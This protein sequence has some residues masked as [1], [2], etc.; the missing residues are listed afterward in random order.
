MVREIV[1]NEFWVCLVSINYNLNS[2]IFV[3]KIVVFYCRL[4]DIGPRERI[5]TPWRRPDAAH[6]V[7]LLVIKFFQTNNILMISG[8][9]YIRNRCRKMGFIIF[10][11]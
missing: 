10:R 1:M 5:R 9:V 3:S 7:P 6:V 2:F 11:S 8:Y 4:R